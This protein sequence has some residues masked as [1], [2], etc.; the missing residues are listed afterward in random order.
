MDPITAIGG[1]DV[2][3]GL[4]KEKR[5]RGVDLEN[6][7]P[8]FLQ[9]L[10]DDIGDD[11]PSTAELSSEDFVLYQ[12]AMKDV[13]SGVKSM[14]SSGMS[15]A[16]NSKGKKYEIDSDSALEEEYR[17][18]GRAMSRMKKRQFSR[19]KKVADKSPMIS[20]IPEKMEIE[21]SALKKIKTVHDRADD[22]TGIHT[23][24]AVS[25]T[26]S[27]IALNND[28]DTSTQP[29]TPTTTTTT[30]LSVWSGEDGNESIRQGTLSQ[31]HVQFFSL[32]F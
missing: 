29:T 20:S 22:T 32:F 30:T 16:I 31:T 5:M 8:S 12:R 13:V 26:H 23:T 18:E 6:S 3:K 4:A 17:K 11:L 27:P 21:G 7:G 1:E 14:A 19:Q 28:T 15:H 24:A 9:M 10:E 25:T 2:M